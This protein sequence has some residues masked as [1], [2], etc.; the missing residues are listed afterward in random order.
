M[1]KLLLKHKAKVDGENALGQV[2]G[3]VTRWLCRCALCRCIA[4]VGCL[5]I[6]RVCRVCLAYLSVFV[7]RHV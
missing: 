2:C 4:F 3:S 1:V 7:C 5:A 6:C